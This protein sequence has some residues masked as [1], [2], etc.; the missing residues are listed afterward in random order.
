M[1]RE[2]G[3][4]TDSVEHCEAGI[5]VGVTIE[6]CPAATLPTTL[7]SGERRSVPPEIFG[8]TAEGCVVDTT[9]V[10]GTGAIVVGGAVV[11]GAT[12]TNAAAV[13]GGTVAGTVVVVAP[14]AIVVGA[15]VVDTAAKAEF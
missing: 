7:P 8:C 10:V 5:V 4:N 15:A 11:V 12:V 9:T 13:V 14:T 1:K 2:S 3:D 6:I